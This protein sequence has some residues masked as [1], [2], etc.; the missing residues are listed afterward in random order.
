VVHS[1][2]F[3]KKKLDFL[4][5]DCS[6]RLSVPLPYILSGVAPISHKFYSF[7]TDPEIDCVV[8]SVVI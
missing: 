5:V 7:K 2:T 8:A 6:R 3:H 4:G 1:L